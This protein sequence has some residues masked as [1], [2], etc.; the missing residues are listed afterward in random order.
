MTLDRIFLYL[1]YQHNLSQ[2]PK[3]MKINFVETVVAR[4]HEFDSARC[5]I[6]AEDMKYISSLLRNNYSNPILATVREIYA[7]AIDANFIVGKDAKSIVVSAPTRFNSVFSV[8][9]FGP[10]LS[11]D[12]MFNLYTKYGKSTKRNNDASIGGFG[13]GRLAP[14]S[15]NSDGFSITSFFNGNKSVYRLYIN[16]D[17]DTKLDELFCEKSDEPNGLLISVGVKDS[18]I[19]TFKNTICN[20][21][22][23]FDALPS[24]VGMSV[25]EIEK[26]NFVISGSNWK[27]ENIERNSRKNYIVM[28]GICY[29]LNFDLLNLESRDEKISH[30]SELSGLYIYAS[31]GSVS[32]HHS[33]E[34]LEY[35]TRTKNFLISVLR[36]IYD[37]L[38]NTVTKEFSQMTCLFQANKKYLQLCDVFSYNL[39]QILEKNN[40]FQFQGTKLTGSYETR[41]YTDKTGS[42]GRIPVLVREFYRQKFSDKISYKR[43][44]T[45][46]FE[47]RSCVVVN[48]LDVGSA[49]LSRIRPLFEKYDKVYV[50]SHNF[51][52][53]AKTDIDGVKEFCKVNNTHLIKEGFYNLSDLPEIKMPRKSL[54]NRLPANFFFK[55]NNYRFVPID[56]SIINDDSIKKAFVPVKNRKME[57]SYFPKNICDNE[58]FPNS[59]FTQFFE[60]VFGVKIIGVSSCICGSKKFIKRNDF[61]SIERVFTDYW[62]NLAEEDK[63]HILFLLKRTPSALEMADF[64]RLLKLDQHNNCLPE[65]NSF[66]SSLEKSNDYLAS[67][68]LNKFFDFIIKH[69]TFAK[70]CVDDLPAKEDG[71]VKSI[72]QK[73]D[74]LKYYLRLMEYSWKFS[75]NLSEEI[76]VKDFANLVKNTP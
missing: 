24:F 36:D 16:E 60:D 12:D 30:F 28:G 44:Y 1:T 43:A 59:N 38:E 3:N 52:N 19:L 74:F 71:V 8:R 11:R 62:N 26:I 13:I 32:I 31:I 56:D 2:F 37:E 4:S 33:R 34:N 5:V 18:D 61:I 67:R 76:I 70:S 45:I 14:L 15:Y 48:D 39:L 68:N 23:A 49:F 10:G 53:A 51:D 20:F 65:L 7:N 17:N 73:H 42:K 9:D 50:V 47:D 55:V 72:L 35:N 63:T 40:F 57:V 66:Q 25:S 46:A 29:P 58:G 41:F 22:R 64:N 75:D 54:S 21:F 6:D 27:I 69:F